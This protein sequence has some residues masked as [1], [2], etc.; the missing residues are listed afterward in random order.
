MNNMVTDKELTLITKA[1]LLT[2]VSKKAAHFPLFVKYDCA[3][4]FDQY[5]VTTSGLVEL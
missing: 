2:S 3:A 5:G 4:F 1:F